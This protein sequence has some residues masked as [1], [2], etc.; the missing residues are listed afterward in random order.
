MTIPMYF[1]VSHTSKY[2]QEPE[3]KLFQNTIYDMPNGS[4]VNIIWPIDHAKGKSQITRLTRDTENISMIRSWNGTEHNSLTWSYTGSSM[5]IILEGYGILVT[6][7]IIF[8]NAQNKEL[9]P[10]NS[11]SFCPLDVKFIEEYEMNNYTAAKVYRTNPNSD[12]NTYPV[13][14]V[15][16]GQSVAH[17][18][19]PSAPMPLSVYMTIP[20]APLAPAS[21]GL[22]LD[23]TKN[24]LADAIRKNDV[25]PITSENITETN[26]TVTSCR[27]VFTTA[28]IK[29]WLSLPSSK[30]LCPICRQKCG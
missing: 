27:H 10:Y 13:P 6:A 21:T 23:T 5:H 11:H 1:A 22:P 8:M 17:R 26:A 12:A 4:R 20:I 30:G 9:L 25:C 29:H 7:P 14:V 18:T 16:I 15:S 3:F 28:A 24:I 19:R 2:N